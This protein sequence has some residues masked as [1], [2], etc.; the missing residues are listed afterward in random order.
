MIRIYIYI[1]RESKKTTLKHGHFIENLK[2]HY[3]LFHAVTRSSG[4]LQLNMRYEIMRWMVKQLNRLWQIIK[5]RY[6][7]VL[8]HFNLNLF[9]CRHFEKISALEFS[10]FPGS[11][12]AISSFSVKQRSHFLVPQ[13]YGEAFA[14]M[15]QTIL[16]SVLVS[17]K[18]QTYLESWVSCMWVLDLNDCVWLLNLNLNSLSQHPR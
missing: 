7:Q 10:I 4:G 16:K 17:F 12:F 5:F 14:A 11:D 1:Y 13:A 15:L 2:N 18:L 9:W 6:G 3:S 8:K